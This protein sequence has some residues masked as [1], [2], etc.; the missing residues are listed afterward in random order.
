MLAHTELRL[1]NYQ[2]RFNLCCTTCVTRVCVL[3]IIKVYN[4]HC[5]FG[6][7]IPYSPALPGFCCIFYC[8]AFPVYSGKK[9]IYIHTI[10]LPIVSSTRQIFSRARLKHASNIHG[11][12]VTSAFNCGDLAEVFITR[13]HVRQ[14]T[15]E[16]LQLCLISLSKYNRVAVSRARMSR[17]SEIG[18][19][20][21]TVR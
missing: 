11:R 16:A 13:Y 15:T 10:F 14:V 19:I 7:I 3:H 4:R 5:N 12:K 1:C 2:V 21:Q 8:S 9:I 18:K 20:E 17:V 6:H